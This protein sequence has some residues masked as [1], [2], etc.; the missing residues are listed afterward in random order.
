MQRISVV[1]FFFF[2]RFFFYVDDTNMDA[3]TPLNADCKTISLANA[4]LFTIKELSC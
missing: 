3:C 2:F 1:T 4:F